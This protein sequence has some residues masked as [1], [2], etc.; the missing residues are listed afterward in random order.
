[1]LLWLLTVLAGAVLLVAAFL[2]LAVLVVIGAIT[3]PARKMTRR[4][5]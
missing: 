1:M 5:P 3:L 2:W 4:V